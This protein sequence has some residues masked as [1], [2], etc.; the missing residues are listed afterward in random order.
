M[1]SDICIGLLSYCILIRARP[2]CSE[3]VSDESNSVTII[4]EEWTERTDA[5]PTGQAEGGEGHHQRDLHGNNKGKTHLSWLPYL[6]ES[7]FQIQ[8]FSLW[9]LL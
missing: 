5:S 4:T 3:C 9:I 1:H 7:T 6:K 8:I 2:V